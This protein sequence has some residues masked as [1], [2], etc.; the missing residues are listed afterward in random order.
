MIVSIEGPNLAGK[1]TK[2]RELESLLEEG[3][4]PYTIIPEYVDYLGDQNRQPDRPLMSREQMEEE[5]RFYIELEK[6]RQQ[7]I[8]DAIDKNGPLHL[9]LTDRTFFTCLAYSKISSNPVSER[10]FQEYLNSDAFILPDTIFF[11]CIAPESEEY[12][13]RKVERMNGNPMCRGL[14]YKVKEYEY[15]YRNMDYE[16]YFRENVA[17]CFRKIIFLDSLKTNARDLYELIR[18]QRG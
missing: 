17:R 3:G 14:S 18:E 6:V 11:L 15:I 5:G 7:D 4:I 2:I 16:R 13:R 12:R 1:T 8:A 10:M 9:V